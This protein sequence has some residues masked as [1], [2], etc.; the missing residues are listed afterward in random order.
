MNLQPIIID[1]DHI[2]C[3]LVKKLLEKC[4]YPVAKSFTSAIDGL[5]YIQK[6]HNTNT[7]YVIFLDINMPKMNGWQFIEELEKNN[8]LSNYFIFIITSSIDENDKNKSLTYSAVM[9]FFTK[10][11]KKS[12]LE[13]LKEKE[14][15]K[16]YF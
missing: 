3:F 2:I 12:L 7:E 6:E 5:D 11:L 15:L 4:N 13:S 1:D 10:P 8:I 14:P 16:I 9:D